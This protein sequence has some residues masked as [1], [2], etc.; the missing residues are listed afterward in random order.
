MAASVQRHRLHATVVTGLSQALALL[1]VVLLGALIAARFGSNAR[2]DGFFFANSIYAIVLFVGQSLRTTTVPALVED[3][4]RN[5]PQLAGAVAILSVAA[6]GAFAVLAFAV[7]PIA[8]ADLP[9]VGRVTAQESLAILWPA[10]VLQLANGL[11]AALLATREQYTAAAMA[12]AIGVTASIGVFLAATPALGI[13]GVPLALVGGT[14][15]TFVVLLTTAMR[16]GGL[17][18]GRPAA[19]ASLHR[20]RQLLLGASG[21]V[22]AQVLVTS[23]V[24]FAATI[25]VGAATV[26]SYAVIAISALL[27][28]TVTPVNV[29]FAPVIAREWDR[30]A[31]SLGRAATRTFRAGA[32][33][34]APAVAAL[35]LLGPGPAKTLLSSLDAATVDEVFVVA[36]IL[37][38]VV[39]TTLAASIPELGVLTRQRFGALALVAGGV[40]IVHLAL[41]GIV[42]AAGGGLRWVAAA[43]TVTSLLLGASMLT[44]GVG[45]QA[46][47]VAGRY[48]RALVE[49][50][51]PGVASFAAAALIVSPHGRLVPGAAAWLLGALGYAGWLWI[52]RRG[53]LLELAS[54]VGLRA[55]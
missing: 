9:P 32:L 38:P 35:V 15:T 23:S 46:A 50:V 5:G 16:G 1:G 28:A 11:V 14:M 41:N 53:E 47:A 13:D 27:A 2:T 43:A 12:Y 6:A 31:E 52:R 24:A 44:L 21:L 42:V 18:L 17:P 3:P 8:T 51:L 25:A 33:I 37:S 39:L 54:A 40:V 55:S 10:A 36:L 48:G 19:A 7:V 29:V 45:R 30:T 20:A 34:S 26:Y 49:L 22:A 4:S